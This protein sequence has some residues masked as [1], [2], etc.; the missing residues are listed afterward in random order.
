MVSPNLIRREDNNNP[1]LINENTKRLFQVIYS[2][3]NKVEERDDET[4]KIKVSAL[5]SRLAFFY[6]KVRNAVDYDEEHLLRKNAIARILR[7]QVMIEGVVKES[8]SRRIAE[9]LLVELIRASYLANGKVPELKI[10]EVTKL[11]E[12]YIRLKNQTV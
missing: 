1:I 2:E 8:D 5:I 6:E 11:L 4:P 12:K 7:R 9:H 3:Q 10:T